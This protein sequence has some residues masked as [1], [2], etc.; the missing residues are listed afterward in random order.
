MRGRTAVKKRRPARFET[1]IVDLV[2]RTGVRARRVASF[3]VPRRAGGPDRDRDRARRPG[4]DSPACWT[5]S[6]TSPAVGR[7]SPSDPT[8]DRLLRRR[9]TRRRVLGS[10]AESPRA[11]ARRVGRPRGRGGGRRHGPWPPVPRIGAPRASDQ[12]L[13]RTRKPGR[14]SRPLVRAPLHRR[15]PALRPLRRTPLSVFPIALQIPSSRHPCRPAAR[16]LGP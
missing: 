7:P 12:R 2:F 14:F 15:A 5:P 4:C 13:W 9:R 16:E 11:R 8:R 1:R 6:S 3:L 10:R